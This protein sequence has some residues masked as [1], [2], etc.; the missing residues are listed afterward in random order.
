[1]IGAIRH[2]EQ[3]ELIVFQQK[4]AKGWKM[5]PAPDRDSVSTAFPSIV[6]PAE[7]SLFYINACGSKGIWNDMATPQIAKCGGIAGGPIFIFDAADMTN[8]LVGQ[9]ASISSFTDFLT[10]SHTLQQI[11]NGSLVRRVLNKI[12][13]ST[14]QIF[15]L[16]VSHFLT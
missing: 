13:R 15:A 10:Q 9:T 1:M 11:N 2:Y 7:S 6:I 12:H 4:Y 5:N 3:Q 16:L 14:R 8:N